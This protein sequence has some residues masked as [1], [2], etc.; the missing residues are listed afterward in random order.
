MCVTYP[1]YYYRR[2][3]QVLELF[4][5]W[6]DVGLFYL[7]YKVEYSKWD[8]ICLLYNLI[9]RAYRR[10]PKKKKKTLKTIMDSLVVKHSHIW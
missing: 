1:T 8:K 6:L 7:K 4:E 9:W 2:F 5:V 10:C 3:K